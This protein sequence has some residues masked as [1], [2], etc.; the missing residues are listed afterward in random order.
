[1]CSLRPT[2]S[3]GGGVVYSLGDFVQLRAEYEGFDVADGALSFIMLSGVY[4]FR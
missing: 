2:A 4:R 1:M 3:Y